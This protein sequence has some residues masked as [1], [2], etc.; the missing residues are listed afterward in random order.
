MHQYIMFIHFSVAGLWAVS[1][2]FAFMINDA[3]DILVYISLI[4]MR[5][6]VW[7]KLRE[8]FV[9]TKSVIGNC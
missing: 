1:S 2:I 5:L 8:K 6:F 3:V 4:D 7:D 9:V